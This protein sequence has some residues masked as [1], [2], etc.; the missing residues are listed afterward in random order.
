MQIAVPSVTPLRTRLHLERE[1]FSLLAVLF[2]LFLCA[3]MFQ[4]QR[5]QLG[6]DESLY[7]SEA[8]NI[9]EGKGLVYTTGDPIV[10]RAPL[11]P[12]IVAGV[13]K[14]TG[15]SL[16]DA[17][18][19][20]RV[21]IVLNLLLVFLLAR[22]M[23]GTWGGIVAGA[24][25]GTS[26]YLRGLGTT[27][28]LDGTETTFILAALLALW[29]SSR[30][31]GVV[32]GAIAGGLLGLAFL[33]KESAILFLPL[34]LV[35][36]L[37]C[38][39]E[40]GWRSLLGGWFG[41]FA[42]ITVW[43]WVWVLAQTGT[44]FLAGEL[45]STL[46][47]VALAGVAAGLIAGGAYLWRAPRLSGTSVWSR[48]FAALIVLAWGGVFLYG[49]DARGYRFDS[50]YAH[51]VPSYFTSVVASNLQPALLIGV[52]W[53]WALA[54]LLRGRRD[55]AMLAIAFLLFAPM[56]LAVAD[57]NLSLRDLLPAVYLS[58]IA[59]GGLAAWLVDWGARLDTGEGMR[60]MRGAGIVL[61]AIVL[62]A[63]VLR[64]GDD[65][66]QA[67]AQTYQ[68]DW[69]N[70]LS[71][72][73][74]GWLDGNVAPGAHVMSTRLYYSHVYFLTDGKYPVYQLPTVEAEI[75]GGELTRRS[76]LFRWEDDR[77][78]AAATA[79]TW[80]YLTR[81]PQKGYLVGMAEDDLLDELRARRIDYVV[82]STADAGFSSP[83]MIEYFDAQPAFRLA[84][85]F[86]VGAA[87]GASIYKVDRSRLTP[88]TQPIQVTRSAFDYL[89]T[90]FGDVSAA[91]A[92]LNA[93]NEHGF[94]INER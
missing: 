28:F 59:A 37:V 38:E 11:Y 77:L 22:A 66:T 88:A 30:R 39:R 75:T 36:A 5:S 48:G 53:V 23:F 10:H 16:D 1:A 85:R 19:V 14:V 60:V 90:R 21:A 67:R 93:A 29:Y 24:L 26:P 18:I 69:Q 78:P 34:P 71:Q 76:S 79:Q 17:Y 25:A 49:L 2:L 46:T 62:G 32:T 13:F 57:R 8:L 64:S 63:V 40:R 35:L 9:A 33:T 89:A 72:Q 94:E 74:A 20:P 68:D 45:D 42:A 43:W 12:A 54:Q 91:V 41:G 65:I 15:V 70:P 83:S 87:D 82:V 58:Y 56:T 55:A 7:V 80:L 84:A 81:Y 61:G 51:H 52:A 4:A 31:Q 44:V 73:V 3:P 6:S 50:D 47:R 92:F 27:L 86:S